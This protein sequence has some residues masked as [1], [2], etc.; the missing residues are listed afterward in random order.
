MCCYATP[1]MAAVVI[2]FCVMLLAKKVF[3]IGTKCV[4]SELWTVAEGS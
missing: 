3:I 1:A 2:G 4:Q